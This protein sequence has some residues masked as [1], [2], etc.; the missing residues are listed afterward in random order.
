MHS[1][2]KIIANH[3]CRRDIDLRL[4]SLNPIYA[5]PQCQTPGIEVGLYTLGTR[6]RDDLLSFRAY[7]DLYDFQEAITGY[8]VVEDMVKVDVIVMEDKP[9]S[10]HARVQIWDFQSEDSRRGTS[11]ST[12]RRSSLAPSSTSTIRRP[13]DAPSTVSRYPTHSSSPPGSFAPSS[14]WSSTNSARSAT[15]QITAIT[16][17]TE[18]AANH[19][20]E[21]QLFEVPK[22]PLLVLFL[23][24][25]TPPRHQ[26]LGGGAAGGFLSM[27]K[28]PIGAGSAALEMGNCTC[29]V[30]ARNP[31]CAHACV[32]GPPKKGLLF[33]AR[34]LAG[35]R[36]AGEG[37][38]NLAV[39][40]AYYGGGGEGEAGVGRERGRRERLN[41]VRLT[42]GR[43]EDKVRFEG[44]VGRLG[45]VD[46]LR[47][48]AYERA[49][50]AMRFKKGR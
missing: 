30:P 35:E 12:S 36:W 20:I 48:D 7:N 18:T 2:S 11:T 25:K 43:R 46:A 40:G 27:L 31:A 6:G 8:R 42:F 19:E 9:T 37:M 41:H 21:A 1:F 44:S 47:W 28:I 23:R 32:T 45:R 34:P 24:S 29:N 49:K 14:Q 39:L 22:E 5:D 4:V 17:L 15:S 13:S 10:Y 26:Q 38:M 3:A 33:G 16:S 50:V